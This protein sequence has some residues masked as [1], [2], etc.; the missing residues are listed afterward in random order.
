MAMRKHLENLS[1]GVRSFFLSVVPLLLLHCVKKLAAFAHL[2]GDVYVLLVLEGLEE[3]DDIFVAAELPHDLHF[4]VHIL[5]GVCASDHGLGDD[6]HC[7]FLPTSLVPCKVGDPEAAF[8]HLLADGVELRDA[9]APQDPLEAEPDLPYARAWRWVGLVAGWRGPSSRSG[10]VLRC[11]R[12][13]PRFFLLFPPHLLDFRPRVAFER[14]HLR[15]AP[16]FWGVLLQLRRGRAVLRF[17]VR[18]DRSRAETAREGR[19]QA[20]GQRRR[21]LRRGGQGGPA[22]APAPWRAPTGRGWRAR[23]SRRR[24]Q[25]R[26]RCLRVAGGRPAL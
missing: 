20:E 19:Y 12:R 18:Y 21:S 25:G 4:P 6:F 13:C 11:G 16:F 14:H 22:H 26:Q 8:A 7:N 24:Q 15:L 17:H 10:V 3:L 5:D 23:A 1:D 9:L 2:H